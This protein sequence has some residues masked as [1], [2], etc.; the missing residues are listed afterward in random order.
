MH[1]RPPLFAALAVNDVGDN[2][3]A[4]SL[5]Y[6][7]PEGPPRLRLPWPGLPLFIFGPGWLGPF[8]HLHGESRS[9]SIELLPGI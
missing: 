1:D 6:E 3:A 8:G 9:R 7:D 4:V 2:V 5:V